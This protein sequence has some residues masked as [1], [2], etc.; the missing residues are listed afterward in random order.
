MDTS[1]Q[2]M[3]DMRT[4]AKDMPMHK[5][6]HEQMMKQDMKQKDMEG[7]QMHTTLMT[8]KMQSNGTP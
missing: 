8:G 3:P 7:M 4:P 6:M 1:K 5:A 2:H